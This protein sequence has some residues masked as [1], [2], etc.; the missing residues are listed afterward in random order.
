VIDLNGKR[1]PFRHAIGFLASFALILSISVPG[2]G[3]SFD[4]CAGQ[5][6]QIPTKM[7][8]TLSLA[9]P[10]AKLTAQPRLSVKR[11]EG[12]DGLPAGEQI[13]PE[14]AP[15]LY[16]RLELA[17]PV[18][19]QENAGKAAILSV[20]A[21][22]E[23]ALLDV[24]LLDGRG[25]LCRETDLAAAQQRVLIPALSVGTIY[26]QR[27]D[28][29]DQPVGIRVS[30]TAEALRPT[31]NGARGSF[32]E[33]LSRGHAYRQPFSQRDYLRLVEFGECDVAGSR[34]TCNFNL[35]ERTLELY[36]SISDLLGRQ[37]RNEFVKNDTGPSDFDPN[38]S[39]SDAIVVFLGLGGLNRFALLQCKS[40]GSG[41]TA[42][43]TCERTQDVGGNSLKRADYVW[44]VYLE[45]NQ[46]PFE[47]SIELEFKS[48]APDVDYEEF[49][50]RSQSRL[51]PLAQPGVDTTTTNRLL[52]I[53]F[54]RFRIREAPTTI[55]GAATA[56]QIAFTRQSPEYGLRQ[57]VKVYRK[58]SD[59]WW[60]VSAG[61]FFP[62]MKVRAQKITLQVE[63]DDQRQNQIGQRIVAVDRYSQV[64]GSLAFSWPQLRGYGR[65]VPGPV[66]A[67]GL[68]P[69]GIKAWFA[70]A[71]WPIDSRLSLVFGILGYRYDN[72]PNHHVGQVLL[73]ATVP[74]SIIDEAMRYRWR[75]GFSLDLWKS[76]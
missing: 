9:S 53:G 13:S 60:Q 57:W 26:I 5:H 52:R 64:F 66:G 17:E 40:A 23:R 49:D 69:R 41:G 21:E 16:V 2:S 54:R 56:V 36:K 72:L 29:G 27:L 19:P 30:L 15:N 6:F 34:Q 46:S 67:V 58:Y 43:R 65:L 7:S 63:L 10:F 76:K 35:S 31:S 68:A 33:S 24:K 48:R 61:L 28:G 45:D 73:N 47:T 18:F 44:A 42:T 55:L 71:A 25:I 59:R 32:V 4:T 74:D 38:P 75:V 50:S 70:G 20:V 1:S 22:D 3:Q 39:E 37:Y 11:T 62:A 8:S 14:A 51:R 12:I